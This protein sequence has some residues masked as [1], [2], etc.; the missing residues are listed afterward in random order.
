MKKPDLS[1]QTQFAHLDQL[2]VF[3]EQIGL[4]ILG[5][6]SLIEM[7]RY[8]INVSIPEDS[9]LIKAAYKNNDWHEIVNIAHRMHSGAL[10]CGTVRLQKICEYI[11]LYGNTDPLLG[12]FLYKLLLKNIRESTACIRQWLK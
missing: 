4:K 11:E 3:D 10:Y 5:E 12:D 1:L 8:L 7:L 6:E 9:L 2:P